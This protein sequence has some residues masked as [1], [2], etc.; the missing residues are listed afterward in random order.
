MSTEIKKLII[1]G[2]G[3]A[4][5]T[6]AIYSARANLNPLIIEGSNPGGQ[7]MSTSFVENWP[8][9]KKIMGPKLMMNMKE[10]AESLGTQFLS[11]SV[12]KVDFSK[13]PFTLWTDRDSELKA[14]SIIIATGATPKRLGVPGEDTYWG[15]G[16][17]TCAVCDGAFF[18][19]KNVV[20]IGGGDTAMEDASFLK[21]FTKQITV[22][23]L[24]DTLTASPAMQERVLNDPDITILYHSTV[25]EFKGDGTRLTQITITN[26]ETQQQ[27]TMAVDGAFLA[28]GMK[29]NTKPFQGQLE[30][31]KW[32]Y[33]TVQNH[34][35]TSVEGIF[36]AG[37]VE[38]FRYRQAISAAGAGCMAALD[39]QA[40][41]G[42]ISQKS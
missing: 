42:Q 26:Q 5:L 32:G 15:K 41:L 4:G 10:H 2:S 3:P 27:T 36:A 35:K 34:T 40:Y 14:E 31:D 6:A 8:G 38:D 30:M 21:K 12:V 19:D 13:K 39:A 7:L 23:Q 37:D 11:E 33:V 1:I 22:I 29:P 24:L 9:E 17:T 28:I 18:K 16:I 20:V 25:T